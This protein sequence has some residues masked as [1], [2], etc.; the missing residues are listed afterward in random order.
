MKKLLLL[1]SIL[2]FACQKDDEEKHCY[3]YIF[4]DSLHCTID[5]VNLTIYCQHILH[6]VDSAEVKCTAS[7]NDSIPNP[8]P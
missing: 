3:R 5:T 2:F 6:L 8:Q 1:I 7:L 4:A